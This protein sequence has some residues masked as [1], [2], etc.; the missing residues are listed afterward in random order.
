MSDADTLLQR[1]SDSERATHYP[2]TRPK[3]AATLLILDRAAGGP[4]RV[5]MGRRHERHRFYPGAYVF[6]GGRVDAGD[7]LAPVAADYHPVVAEKLAK[8][9]KNGR[10]GGRLRAFG[11]SAVR[12]TFE[13]A[14]LYLGRP[15]GGAKPLGGDLAP[16]AAKGLALDLSPLVFVARAIT[17]PRRPRR[18]DTR[19]FAV[20]IDAVAEREPSGVGPSGELEALAWLTFEEAKRERLPTITVTI[21]DELEARLA[22]DGGL[23]PETAAPFYYF[24]GARFHRDEL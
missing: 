6:P 4:H 17:P 15:D 20:G 18:F 8:E 5:L 13:E 19:F 12:E 9:M 22:R 1:L 14:G 24:R 16:F 23:R 7:A 3:D 21:L 11:V 10:S 2:N